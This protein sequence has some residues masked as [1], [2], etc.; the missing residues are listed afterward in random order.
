MHRFC[1]SSQA[2]LIAA[3]LQQL[4]EDGMQPQHL[5]LLVETI[6]KSRSVLS[7]QADIVELVATGTETIGIANR[8]TGVGSS[9]PV[10]NG[11]TDVLVAGFAVHKG[12][13]VFQR[14]AERMEEIPSLRVR[15]FLD[16]QRHQTDTSLKSELLL[17]FVHR[18]RTQEWPGEKLPEIHYDPRSLDMESTKRSSMHAKCIVVDRR[19]SFV[20]S[21]NFTEAAQMRNIEVGA[22]I[23][24]EQFAAQL[25][26]HFETLADAGLLRVV[27]PA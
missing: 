13:S 18:F 14:L 7:Q 4:H 1:Q 16:V 3:R 9:R 15:L 6:A 24:S 11:S 2:A 5:A 8:D 26:G 23:R 22:L 27:N 21:A 19:V 25:V 10:R 17:R 20:S 12:R